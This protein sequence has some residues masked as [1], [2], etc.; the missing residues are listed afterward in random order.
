MI[1]RG[2][3]TCLLLCAGL[4]AL[5][6]QEALPEGASDASS[7]EPDVT[8]SEQLFRELA[9]RSGGL[10]SVRVVQDEKIVQMLELYRNQNDAPVI[11][12]FRIRIFSAAG[13]NARRQALEEMQRFSETYPGV[14]PYLSYDEPYFKLYVGD[15]RIKTDALRFLR[16][17]TEEYPH[18]FI[19][20]DNIRVRPV[21]VEETV[22]E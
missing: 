4:A 18:A 7:A 8:S 17:V 13:N 16:Q 20:A 12:G 11:P 9:G 2:I 10:G 21:A 22:Q 1:Q 3:W 19:S 5:S 15:F 6:A 14:V